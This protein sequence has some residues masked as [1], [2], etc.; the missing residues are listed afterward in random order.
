M[1]RSVFHDSTSRPAARTYDALVNGIV[2]Q[3][4]RPRQWKVATIRPGVG[5]SFSRPGSP[6]ETHL[7]AATM[8]L[9]T[10]HST[11]FPVIAGQLN[12]TTQQTLA[13]TSGILSGTAL[14]IHL[15]H[16][17]VASCPSRQFLPLA[18][19]AS[20]LL[21]WSLAQIIALPIQARYLV[22]F[23]V[24][25]AVVTAV[26][27]DI[28]AAMRGVWYASAIVTLTS[29]MW[30]ALGNGRD[31]G[32]NYG[33]TLNN[34]YLGLAS[35]LL[36]MSSLFLPKTT[37]KALLIIGLASGA[38][39]LVLAGS[40]SVSLGVAAGLLVFGGSRLALR[41]SKHRSGIRKLRLGMLCLA[42]STAIIPVLA[43][44]HTFRTAVLLFDSNPTWSGRDRFFDA[45]LYLV[46]NEPWQGNG[47]RTMLTESFVYADP[48][49][50][51]LALLVMFGVPITSALAL[52]FFLSLYQQLLRAS[53]LVFVLAFIWVG[54][55]GQVLVW[56]LSTTG[57]LLW[58]I[59]LT[60][61]KFDASAPSRILNIGIHHLPEIPPR[62]KY[63][64]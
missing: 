5:M 9:L 39:G 8:F 32:L 61:I 20:T 53:T 52:V 16:R 6:L 45:N 11:R 55:A 19:L 35:G 18:A 15:S 14:L 13:A 33:L 59:C 38:C 46:S 26:S 48:H 43:W 40:E 27:L 50:S 36:V 37:Q 4:S 2:I 42:L 31:E 28:K 29:I 30:I 22:S 34:Y 21:V 44:S 60:T 1:R 56:P 51:A 49:N 64:R 54:G 24:G 3:P 7:I 23:A 63:A 25:L 62:D 58:A 47:F 41:I 12:E 10:I 17:R 57:A